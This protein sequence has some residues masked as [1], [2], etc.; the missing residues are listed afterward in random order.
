MYGFD[1]LKLISEQGN[2]NGEP[3]QPV[4]MTGG[5]AV[6]GEEPRWAEMRQEPRGV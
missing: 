4:V 3:K 6:P 2:I 5:G 1:L